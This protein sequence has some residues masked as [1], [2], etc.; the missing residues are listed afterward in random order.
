MIIHGV[1][2]DIIHVELGRKSVTPKGLAPWRNRL[3]IALLME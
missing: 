2:T 3:K 1:M